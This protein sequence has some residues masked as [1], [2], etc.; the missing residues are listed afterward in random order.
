[1]MTWNHRVIK[2]K[3]GDKEYFGI[4][5]VHYD[6]NGK[7]GACTENAIS[8]D[9]YESLADVLWVLDRMREALDKPVLNYEDF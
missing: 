8:I 2:R 9:Y 3:D 1:M 7:P 6:E 4:H 5:E